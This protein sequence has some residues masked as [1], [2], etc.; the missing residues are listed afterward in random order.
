[1]LIFPAAL[2]R[3]F[4]P[5]THYFLAFYIGLH[6]LFVAVTFLVGMISGISN[7][8]LTKWIAPIPNCAFLLRLFDQIALPQASEFLQFTGLVT[9]ASLVLVARAMTLSREG[10]R[11]PIAD[12]LS[13]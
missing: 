9:V 12:T 5:S 8:P 6:G 4:K 2:I 7:E 13:R 3:L 11:R 1:M 10:S